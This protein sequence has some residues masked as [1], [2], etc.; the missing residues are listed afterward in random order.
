MSRLGWGLFPHGAPLMLL[1][2]RLLVEMPGGAALRHPCSDAADMHRDSPPPA[3]HP[4]A[5]LPPAA[6]EALSVLMA[7]LC[8][9]SGSGGG[10]GGSPASPTPSLGRGAS[11][12]EA[13][14]TRTRG[15]SSRLRPEE[16]WHVPTR[17]K[18]QTRVSVCHGKSW[19][20][21]GCP[22]TGGRTSQ[23]RLRAVKCQPAVRRHP[24][25]GRGTTG[26]ADPLQR[27]AK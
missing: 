15:G 2:V 21:R 3:A 7:D 17:H 22:P 14:G 10:R 19:K 6:N 13:E 24:R 12:P 26:D 5:L 16:A 25:L 18:A 8:V 9:P 4:P 20:G 1:L 27:R 11:A 23:R